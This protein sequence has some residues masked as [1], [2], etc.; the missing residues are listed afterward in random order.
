MAWGQAIGAIVGAVTGVMTT[1]LNNEAAQEQTEWAHNQTFQ[2]HFAETPE[3]TQSNNLFRYI[4]LALIFIGIIAF[5][6]WL[7]QKFSKK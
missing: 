7:W 1:D 5:L 2:N 4:F 6:I 3:E